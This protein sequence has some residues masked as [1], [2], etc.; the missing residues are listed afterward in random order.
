MKTVLRIQTSLF[1]A[2][3]QS[4][5]LA[6]RFIEGIRKKQ[7]EIR[8][9]TRDLAAESVPALTLERFQALIA[10]PED[11]SLEQQAVVDFS[12]ALIAELKSADVIVFAVPMYNFT[13]PAALHNY[14]DHLARAGVTFRYTADGPE[15]LIKGKQVA[16]F[17]TRGGN[18]GEDHSQTAFL[19]QF[20]SFIGLDDAMYF[21]AEGLAI[22]DESREKSLA[23]ARNEIAA[24]LRPL[25]SAA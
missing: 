7:G 4:S 22:S 8:V 2:D 9:V 21:H 24:A 18:H 19:R 1:G 16:V 23:A 15:G 14:F 10:K 5:K 11:R 17:V 13:I 25:A 20:L 3:G 12:D 6:D